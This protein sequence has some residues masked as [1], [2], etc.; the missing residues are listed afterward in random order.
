MFTGGKI[1][2]MQDFVG[3]GQD[4]VVLVGYFDLGVEDGLD[5]FAEAVFAGMM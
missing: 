4:H 3:V 5:F 2:E 1:V